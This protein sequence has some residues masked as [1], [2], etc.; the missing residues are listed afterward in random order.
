MMATRA[1]A[2][3][4]MARS[5]ATSAAPGARLSARRAAGGAEP[6]SR[7]T[8][9]A[10][11]RRRRARSSRPSPNDDAERAFSYAAP[12]IRAMFGTPERFLAMVRAGYPVVY[13]AGRRRPSCIPLR[14]DGQ[15]VQGVH[16]TDADGALWLAAYRLERQPDGVVAHQPAATCSR[17]RAR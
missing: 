17:H 1:A 8:P 12:S 9:S 14:V 6:V 5:L 4:A 16:L 13:R 10:V 7:P 15:L 11:A 2:G 3:D